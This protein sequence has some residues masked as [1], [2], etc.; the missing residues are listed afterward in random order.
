MSFCHCVSVVNILAA[1]FNCD[2]DSNSY[3]RLIPSF[4]ALP[5]EVAGLFTWNLIRNPVLGQVVYLDLLLCRGLDL[6]YEGFHS[7]TLF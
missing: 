4:T 1:N 2:C 6:E 7:D 3:Q 5:S